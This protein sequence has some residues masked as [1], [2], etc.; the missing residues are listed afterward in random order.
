MEVAYLYQKLRKD[1]GKD[2]K[3]TAVPA[4]IIESIP[5]T[6]AYQENYIFRNPTVSLFDTAPQ[7]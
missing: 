3:F 6:E 7:M 1:F 2:C 5:V 4:T